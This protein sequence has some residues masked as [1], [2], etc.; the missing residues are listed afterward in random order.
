MW[1]RVDVGAIEMKRAAS[2][3]LLLAASFAAT[4]EQTR[5]D[6]AEQA[7]AVA[8]AAWAS[9]DQ[10]TP[11]GEKTFTPASLARFE[12]YTATLTD[13]IWTFRGTPV[14]G[15]AERPPL[16]RVRASTGEVMSGFVQEPPPR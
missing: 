8:R 5:I 2:A 7:L 10:R 9:F 4:A 16:T 6:T 11:A 14:A 15:T 1:E 13:G 12:P 3:M